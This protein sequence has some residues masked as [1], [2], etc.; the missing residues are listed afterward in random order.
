[1]DVKWGHT[2]RLDPLPETAL[3][4]A[5]CWAYEFRNTGRPTN[6]GWVDH[7]LTEHPALAQRVF[8]AFLHPLLERKI[9]HISLLSELASNAKTR[10]WGS[11][12]ALELLAKFASA[13]SK[14]LRHL[15]YTAL[16]E[17]SAW[18]QLAEL[19]KNVLVA[20]GRVRGDQRVLWIVTGYLL[21]P[22][23]FSEYPRE[24]LPLPKRSALDNHRVCGTGNQRTR[25]QQTATDC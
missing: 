19:A 5:L 13:P 15:L 17:E 24:L 4:A 11:A 16:L 20:R 6:R 14:S 10:P 3:E 18:G 7:I 12:L 23:D 2:R 1:M 8:G 22:K 25:E 9:A 21:S